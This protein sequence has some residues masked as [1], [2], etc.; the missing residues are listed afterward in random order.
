VHSGAR[1]PKLAPDCLE[2]LRL[3]LE[4]EAKLDDPPLAHGQLFERAADAL[5]AECLFRLLEGVGGGRVGEEVAELAVSVGAD[6]LVERD[7]GLG[8]TK[9]VADVG[10]AEAGCLGKLLA[11]RLAVELGLKPSGGPCQLPS[12]L[13]DV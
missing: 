12:T 11:G 5:A 6:R 9:R 10:E 8:D 13:E 1:E 3:A 7:G 2:R 4:A